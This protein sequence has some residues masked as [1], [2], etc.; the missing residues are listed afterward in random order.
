[1]V[2]SVVVQWQNNK[3]QTLKNVKGD[4]KILVDIKNANQSVSPKTELK[5][6]TSWFTN[7]TQQSGVQYTHQQ[8]DL[9][10]FNIQ[11][12]LPHKFSEYGPG[13]AVADINGDGFDD[14]IVGA[15]PNHS[16]VMFF[17]NSNGSFSQ[18][19]LIASEDQAR[20][21]RTDDRGIL[22]FDADGD[23]D[24]DLYVSSGGYNDNLGD[25]SYL[26]KF[27][28]ND[29]KGNFTIDTSA[30]PKNTKSKFCVRACD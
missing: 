17:Q 28:V 8:R 3:T 27:Y 10:D 23:G 16:T 21:K 20:Y 5:D 24:P 22:M 13:I 19:P 18:K 12:L 7:I 9:I 25:S 30:I 2:D 11:K 29:G 1:M 14:F 15:S 26:D 4:Q 6:R